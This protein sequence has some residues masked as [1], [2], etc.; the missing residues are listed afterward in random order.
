MGQETSM[1]QPRMKN[2]AAIVPGAV[3][4]VQALM[5]TVH[6]AEVPPKVRHL[7]HLRVSQINGCSFCVDSA[8]KHAKKDGETDERLHAVGAWRDMPYFSDAER[9]ALELAEAATRLN[10]QSDPVP[11]LVWNDAAMHYDEKQLAGL[12]LWIA[13]VNLFNRI[14]VPVRQPIGQ[15]M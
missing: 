14:N 9:A 4:A 6:T 2:P 11:D 10:D 13:I 3:Q 8:V 12:L 7:V 5:A 15:A 1:M